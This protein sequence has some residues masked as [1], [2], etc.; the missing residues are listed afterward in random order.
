MFFLK[1][2][3]VLYIEEREDVNEVCCPI[4]GSKSLRKTVWWPLRHDQ[5]TLVIWVG[6]ST[7]LLVRCLAT[8]FPWIEMLTGL[9]ILENVQISFSSATVISMLLS[10][11]AAK[12][13]VCLLYRKNGR[14]YGMTCDHCDNLALILKAKSKKKTLPANR[15][16]LTVKDSLQ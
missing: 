5:S 9:P 6:L 4:C 13:I 1:K 16:S 15:F 10:Y 12:G 11:W 7:Y 3:A 14:V 8:V 2:D